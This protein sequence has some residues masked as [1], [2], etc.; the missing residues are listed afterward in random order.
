MLKL[1]KIELIKL[2][3]H[4]A[5]RA[6]VIIWIVLFCILRFNFRTSLTTALMSKKIN[7]N[8]WYELMGFRMF[9]IWLISFLIGFIVLVFFQMEHRNSMLKQI[10]L[11][12]ISSYYFFV[13]KLITLLISS[14]FFLMIYGCIYGVCTY[15]MGLTNYPDLDF[16][17]HSF[18]AT[19]PFQMTIILKIYISLLG[20]LSILALLNMY[21][22]N[23]IIG[24]ALVVL[25]WLPN[26]KSAW[27]TKY[28]PSNFATRS[29]YL[30]YKQLKFSDASVS[31]LN[32][33][34]F[35]LYSVMILVFVLIVAYIL[36]FKKRLIL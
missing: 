30:F 4:N 31:D 32:P 34:Q 33:Y 19:I 7:Q 28:F 6:Y 27:Y 12:P 36:N 5:I 13:I 1:I 26:I 24:A 29:N 18:I 20:Y 21:I 10:R 9:D 25:F 23:V 2:W 14:F 11:L 17:N 22:K 35:E 8:I 16:K 3:G 15:Y